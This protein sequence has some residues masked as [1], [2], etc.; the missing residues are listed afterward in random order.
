MGIIPPYFAGRGPYFYKLIIQQAQ[1]LRNCFS[2]IFQRETESFSVS[3]EFA[4][5]N[6]QNPGETIRILLKNRS[7]YGMI[8]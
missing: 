1:I 5:N 3:L 4:E 8:L 2:F 7:F 6:T